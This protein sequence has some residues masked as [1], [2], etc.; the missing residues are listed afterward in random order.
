MQS[1]EFAC[2]RH[3]EVS[4]SRLVRLQLLLILLGNRVLPRRK[5]PERDTRSRDRIIILF[6][7]EE[8]TFRATIIRAPWYASSQR[9]VLL[10]VPIKTRFL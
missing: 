3:A 5:Q 10:F 7:H 6:Y 4:S 1:T 9:I 2:Q 8:G